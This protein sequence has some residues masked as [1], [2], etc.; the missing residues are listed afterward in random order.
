MWSAPSLLHFI[1]HYR[2]KLNP[3]SNVYDKENLIILGNSYS[4]EHYV[5]DGDEYSA[6][7]ANKLKNKWW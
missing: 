4:F 1:L 2:G 6:I 5:N 7:I 3:I